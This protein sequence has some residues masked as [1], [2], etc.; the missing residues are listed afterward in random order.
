MKYRYI[1]ELDEPIKGCMHCPLMSQFCICQQ[2]KKYVGRDDDSRDDDCPLR[3]YEE[4]KM[5]VRDILSILRD[6][7]PST[8]IVLRGKDGQL[9]SLT[10]HIEYDEAGFALPVVEEAME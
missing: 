2:L 9:H 6:I 10:V 8:R 7:N 5:E 1:I 4:R 3:E